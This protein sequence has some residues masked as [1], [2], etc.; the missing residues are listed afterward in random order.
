MGI[1]SLSVDPPV[2]L[3]S[4][5]AGDALDLATV[6]PALRRDNPKRRTA[7]L[8]FAVLAG[9]TLVDLVAAKSVTAVHA[10]SPN[11]RRNYRDRSGFPQ[12]VQAARGAAS[13]LRARDDLATAPRLPVGSETKVAAVG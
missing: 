10:R 2:G 4:R 3:W 12:G 6:A 13:G 8:A 9:V 7:A 1:V 11:P 5:V